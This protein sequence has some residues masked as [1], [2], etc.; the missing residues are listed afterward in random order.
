MTAGELPLASADQNNSDAQLGTGNLTPVMSIHNRVMTSNGAARLLP[1][2]N[3][4]AILRQQ[5]SVWE[6]VSTAKLI[7]SPSPL[8]TT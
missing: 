4:M 8:T 1:R 2:D 5:W 7:N 6:V 3:I